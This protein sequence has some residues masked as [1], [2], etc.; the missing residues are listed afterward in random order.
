MDEDDEILD[1]FLEESLEHLEGVESDLLDIEKAGEDIDV[2]QVNKVFRAMHT[3]AANP[4]PSTIESQNRVTLGF[5][6]SNISPFL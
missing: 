5:M 2:D 1:L 4:F 3:C 6:D